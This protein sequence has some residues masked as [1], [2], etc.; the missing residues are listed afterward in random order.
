MITPF[1]FGF[2]FD[3]RGKHLG[4]WWLCANIVALV[5]GIIFQIFAT[6]IKLFK[7]DK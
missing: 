7:D 2:D 5:V 4:E 6:D 3:R 1:V